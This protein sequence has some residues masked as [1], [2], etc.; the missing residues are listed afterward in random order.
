MLTWQAKASFGFEQRLFESEAFQSAVCVV[1]LGCGNASYA[2]SLASAY[3]QKK[4]IGVDPD[5]D[6]IERARQRSLPA[7]L[8]LINGTIDDVPAEIEIDFLLARLM[9]MYVPAPEEVANAVYA[10]VPEVLVVDAAD[11]VFSVRPP[12]PLFAETLKANESRIKK[13]GGS[14]DME[15]RTL[16][17]W[18]D[19]GYRLEA[20]ET[21]L[22]QSSAL[23]MKPV[24]HLLMLL[25]AELVVGTPL[26]PELL[27]E[28]HG[29]VFDPCSY[30]QYGLRARRFRRDEKGSEI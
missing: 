12:V 9:M 20:E 2:A 25:N 19:S 14:R 11:D 15:S 10:R 24:M 3:P 13:L 18:S 26:N 6:L 7:N 8:D 17:I 16:Q 29:W 27:S 1:D 5:R 30:L 21:I 23:A 28:L 22:V 4:I